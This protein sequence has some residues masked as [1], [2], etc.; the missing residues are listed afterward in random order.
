MDDPGRGRGAGAPSP[1]HDNVHE[2][3]RDDHNL[4]DL[5][6]FHVRPD[7]LVGEGPA[8]DILAAGAERSADAAAELAVDLNRNLGLLLPRQFGV[9]AGPGFLKHRICATE[10]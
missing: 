1:L 10:L 7:L 5:F 4:Y 9:V 8:L 3:I 2:L 6:A